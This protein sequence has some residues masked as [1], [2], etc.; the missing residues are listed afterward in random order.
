MQQADWIVIETTEGGFDPTQ[1]HHKETVFTLSNGYL[2][3]RGS[4]EE[5]YPG[6]RPA[7]LI[8]GVY[9]DVPTVFTELANCPNWLSL[10]V[11]IE[12]ES[13]HLNQGTLLNYKRWLDLYRGVLSRAVQWQSPAGH[14]FEFR[15]DRFVSLADEHVLALRC[16]VKS[17]NYQGE[18]EVHAPLNGYA[19]NHGYLHWD[20]VKGW[21]ADRAIGLQLRSRRSGIELG[22]TARLSVFGAES[23]RVT[24]LVLQHCPTLVGSFSIQPAQVVSLEKTVTVFTSRD[25]SNPL[26]AAQQKQAC[27]PDYDEL[28][29]AHETAWAQMWEVSDVVIEGDLSAQLAVRFNLF[30][31]LSATPR[32]DRQVSIPA[33]TLSGFAYHGHVFWDTEIFILPCLTYTHPHLAQHLL[34]YRYHTLAGARQKARSAGYEGAMYAWESAATGKDVT[35]KWVPNQTQDSLIRIWCGEIEQHINTDIA[36]AIWHYWQAT[37]DHD[38]MRNYGAE[39]ILDTAVFWGSRVEWNA[40][41]DRFEIS[42]VIGPDEYHEQVNN[43]AFTNGMVRWHLKTALE[44]LQWLRRYDLEQAATLE[45][46]LNLTSDR[47]YHWERAI[48]KLWVSHDPKT[49]LIEQFQGFFDLE[50]IDLNEY[51]PRSLSMQVILGIEGANQRQ[52]LKQPDVLMLHYLLRQGIF[53]QPDEFALSQEHLQT[54][55]NYYSPRTDHTYGS[56]L[57]PAV[58]AILGC[59]LGNPTEAYEHFQ[60]AALVDLSDV[61]RNA[62]EGIH[63]AST[64]GT[65]QA[66][67]FGFG[68][69]HLT[70]NGPVATPHLPAHWTRLK[71]KFVWQGKV[72]D[73]D[74]QQDRAI[75]HRQEKVTLRKVTP[76]QARPAS[77]Q[78][79]AVIFDLDG[80]LTDTSEMHYLSWKRLAD[81]EGIPFDRQANEALRGVS[82]RDSLLF[83]LQDRRVDEAQLQAMMARKNA[84]YLEFIRTIT[85]DH[86]L[87]GV[88]ELLDELRAA[89]VKVAVGSASKNA[90]EVIERLGIRNRVDAIADGNSVL[91]S[92]PAPDVFLH[93]AEQLG[94]A[95]PHCLVVEDAASGIEAA[96]RAGMW[97]VG[98]GPAERVGTAHIVLPNLQ[99][100]SWNDLQTKLSRLQPQRSTEL[101]VPG[102]SL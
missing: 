38:W 37:V 101:V 60:R 35:P 87:A 11:V 48:A 30:Q 42:N 77:P 17:I 57:G 45:R 29:A 93:A 4:F 94:V 7:T 9:D 19:D 90:V 79:K 41:D 3:T 98:L 75:E 27:L 10:T 36:Y 95:P 47:L 68:G 26:E 20:W 13:F 58:H 34:S 32:Q 86:L 18:V 65:W 97:A 71:F 39:I 15:F 33:K 12:G 40:A 61:R 44:V 16:Q 25:V 56:S 92:K 43:N 8:N 62:H 73:F 64:G 46:R 99:E 69:L 66:V 84:Y 14:I 82:R 50:D 28:V 78:L 22:M 52:V 55:W 53:S 102:K 59:E 74:L 31:L 81:E 80:V 100:T 96:L 21:G 51:E 76:A 88:P 23:A 49:G 54:N 6:D 91:H 72:Y 70:E 63:G 67:V 85:P 24:P 89:G 83:L 2:G 5:S 1:L